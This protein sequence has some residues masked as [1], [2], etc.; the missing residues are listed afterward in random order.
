MQANVEAE[1]DSDVR[2]VC[3]DRVVSVTP[4]SLDMTA[5]WTGADSLQSLGLPLV[6]NI[7]QEERV[8]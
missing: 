1:E 2:A 8:F 4:L 6:R 3:L 7:Y 5:R